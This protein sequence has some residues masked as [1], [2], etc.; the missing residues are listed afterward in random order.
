MS[1]KILLLL[2]EIVVL[3]S[4]TKKIKSPLKMYWMA[5]AYNVFESKPA[6]RA[7]LPSCSGDIWCYCCAV[8][9]N[10]DIFFLLLPH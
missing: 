2:P 6:I 7:L 4:S 9:Q 3:L 1:Y 5:G 8:I 10:S